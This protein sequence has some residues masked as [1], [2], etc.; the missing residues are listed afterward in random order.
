VVESSQDVDLYLRSLRLLDMDLP[1]LVT[2][3]SKLPQI[4]WS[5]SWSTPQPWADID[6]LEHCAALCGSET[7]V[8]RVC[9]EYLLFE[10]RGMI[11]VLRHLM[12]MVQH[13]RS[14]N[15]VWGV[16]RGSSVSSYVLFLIGINR[17]DPLKFNLDVSE[18]LK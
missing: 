13:L 6:V 16:G 8:Q 3:Q 12:Y 4:D 1:A 5:G 17:I 11:P 14:Q 9:E 18:F 7:E 10:E 2:E 15:I